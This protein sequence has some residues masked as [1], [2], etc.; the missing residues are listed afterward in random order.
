MTQRF[1]INHRLTWALTAALT[2]GAGLGSIGPIAVAAPAPQAT[3]DRQAER[4]PCQVEPIT[5]E[6]LV[7]ALDA[8]TPALLV[9]FA[10]DEIPTGEPVDDATAEAITDTVVTSLNCRNAGDFPRVYSLFSDRMIGQLFGGRE[11]VPPEIVA[12]L[13]EPPQRVRPPLRVNLVEID[14]INQLPD[15]R[16]SAVVT[17][18]NSTHTF[19][20]V[21][22]FVAEGDQWLIDEAVAVP[23]ATGAATATPVP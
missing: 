5:S 23:G 9:V 20:D 18:A 6:R 17:T 21:L 7:G 19:T 22:Y 13:S 4:I 8:A 2:L 16:V 10:P 15:G 3:T 12:A 1:A 11:T 14:A